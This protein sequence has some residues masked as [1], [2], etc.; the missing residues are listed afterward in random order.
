MNSTR[1]TMSRAARSLRTRS[2]SPVNPRDRTSITTASWVMRDPAARPRSTIRAMSSGGRLSATYQPRSSSTLAAVP[3]P[4]PDRPVT[5]TTSMSGAASA[6][7][8]SSR[9]IGHGARRASSSTGERGAAEWSVSWARER[10]EH[11]GGGRD[12]DAGDGGDLLHAGL[13]QPGQRPEVG[14]QRLAPGLPQSADRIQCRGRHPLG[15]L[16]AVVGDREA[17]RLVANPLQQVQP[18]A[19]AR[20]DHRVRFGRAPTPPRVAWPVRSPPRR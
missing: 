5:S 16:T 9:V 4:A 15:P 2:R 6:G 11:R 17:V 20:Q 13:A 3:R 19:V 1:G 12:P 14:H 18:L 10:V 8:C 7:L